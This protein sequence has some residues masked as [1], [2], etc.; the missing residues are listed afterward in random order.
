METIQ[1]YSL[2]MIFVGTI[3]ITIAFVVQQND[4]IVGHC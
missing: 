3:Y 2:L 1:I 4:D